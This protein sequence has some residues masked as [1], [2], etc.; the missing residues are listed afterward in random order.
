MHI[1]H[2]FKMSQILLNVKLVTTAPCRD[3][4]NWVNLQSHLVNRGKPFIAPSKSHKS[5]YLKSG[6]CVNKLIEMQIYS[7]QGSVLL[8]RTLYGK[9]F[10]KRPY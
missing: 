7:K 2:G 4:L 1:G 5:I 8:P 6:H 3:K 9:L 10:T